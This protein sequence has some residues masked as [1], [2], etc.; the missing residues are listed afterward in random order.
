MYWWMQAYEVSPADSDVAFPRWSAT[1]DWAD[2]EDPRGSR[3][4]DLTDGIESVE[5]LSESG[6]AG[7]WPILRFVGTWRAITELLASHADEP[8]IARTTVDDAVERI[9]RSMGY[10]PAEDGPMAE[11]LQ[12][13]LETP[14]CR[15]C[16]WSQRGRINRKT[17][18]SCGLQFD[19]V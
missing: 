4:A 1:F 13:A 18:P 3:Y 8:M 10:Q 17:C 6:P 16:G 2:A 7:G 9:A 5:T 14:G 19:W 11:W 15:N 12:D